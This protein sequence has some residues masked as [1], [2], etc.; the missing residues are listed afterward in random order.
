MIVFAPREN[1]VEMRYHMLTN[2]LFRPANERSKPPLMLSTHSLAILN[3]EPVGYS[4]QA[5][6]V[7]EELGA[8]HEQEVSRTDLLSM[9]GSYNVL[10]VR[11]AHQIDR[12]V[13]D[14]SENLRVI[15]TATTGVDHIDMAYAAQKNIEV[16]S[17]RGETEFLKRISATAEHTWAILLALIRHVPQAY[18]H[19]HEGGWDRDLFQGT[20]LDGKRLGIVGLGRIGHK[21]ARYAQAFNMNVAA[22]DPLASDWLDHVERRTSLKDLLYDSDIVSLHVPLNDD[23]RQMMNAEAFGYLP[24]GAI[25]INTSRGD[26]V[27][28]AALVA[29]LERGQL[30]AAALDVLT[31]ERDP[32]LRDQSPILVYSRSH[33]N[34]LITPHIGGATYESMRNTELFMAHKLKRYLQHP[35]VGLLVQR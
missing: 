25:L 6:A 27:E 1:G 28:E 23:T 9:I 26:I 2:R 22:Y 14:A 17:L 24:R 16:L 34:L 13:I 8:L 33:S 19:V 21:V 4:Q 29:A 7:L 32:L 35:D 30:A 15:V 18:H 31:H 20:E 10:I 11:L 5:R 12:E 3:I